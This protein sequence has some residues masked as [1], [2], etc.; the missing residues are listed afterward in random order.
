MIVPVSLTLSTLG[1]SAESE[2]YDPFNVTGSTVTSI[3][4]EPLSRATFPC[5]LNSR[6]ANSTR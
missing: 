3:R 6:F 5:P 4:P 1:T 2:G